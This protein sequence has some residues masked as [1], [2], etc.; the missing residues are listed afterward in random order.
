MA[1]ISLARAALVSIVIQTLFFG[2]YVALF[3]FTQHI[4]FT[5]DRGSFNRLLWCASVLLFLISIAH[6]SIDAERLQLAFLDNASA[7]DEFLGSL[8][9]VT[10]LA[11]SAVYMV[12]TYIGDACII[13]RT[14]MLYGKNILVVAL[15][16]VLLVMVMVTGSGLLWS[17]AH[18]TSGT[19]PFE[20]AEWAVPYVG[21]TLLT[22]LICTI[23]I[24][25]RIWR[26][27]PLSMIK[28]DVVRFTPVV[29]LLESGAVYTASIAILTALCSTS[30]NAYTIILDLL[31]PIIGITFSAI[32]LRV[33]SER[34]CQTPRIVMD[35]ISF[36]GTGTSTGSGT[37][38]SRS[39][40]P[41][42]TT[43]HS[44]SNRRSWD[45]PSSDHASC[46]VD[47]PLQRM[48]DVPSTSYV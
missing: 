13:Y 21:G 35:V 12:Q 2:V 27:A 47:F 16:A 30:S 23:L 10:Y 18:A 46:V 41:I 1:G 20:F 38:R 4:I 6:I 14:Y 24:I 48:G 22:N 26:M 33:Y 32:I 15:P 5:D 44:K 3:L 31:C 36:A 29:V 19:T 39:T 11:K 28:R 9:E 17:F 8:S 40:V 43:H 7:R 34:R 42:G 37:Q 45:L 25:S